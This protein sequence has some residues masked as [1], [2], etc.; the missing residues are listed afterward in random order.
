M[1]YALLAL[2]A[3]TPAHGYELKQAYEQ[4]VG[5]VQPPLNAGQIYTTLA[6]LERDGLVQDQHVAQSDRPDKRVYE[7]TSAGRA[8]LDDWVNATVE[9]PYLKDEFFTKLILAK[10]AGIADPRLLIEHQRHGYLQM[11]RNLNELALYPETRQDVTTSLLIE[12]V[13]L[14]LQASLKWLDTCEEKLT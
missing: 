11:L 2:L 10:L 13:I 9:S 7:L 8:A 3:A 6:R 5:A 14:H 12:G 4:L 1:K